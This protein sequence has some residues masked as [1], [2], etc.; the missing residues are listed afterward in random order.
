MVYLCVAT[1]ASKLW[2][3]ATTQMEPKSGNLTRSRSL[4]QTDLEQLALLQR[5]EVHCG[6]DQCNRLAAGALW[7]KCFEIICL[8]FWLWM[9]ALSLFTQD[10]TTSA[11]P[12][13]QMQWE[14][15][16]YISNTYIRKYKYTNTW[17]WHS[18]IEPISNATEIALIYFS[19]FHHLENNTYA[20]VLTFTFCT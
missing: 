6:G 15:L 4:K 11:L 18:G 17:L 5:T 3:T 12:H 9:A 19:A 13:Y 1:H 10:P 14:L 16:Q 8:G 2:H 7:W 20:F